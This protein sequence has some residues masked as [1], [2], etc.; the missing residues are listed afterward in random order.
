MYT[1]YSLG[2]TRQWSGICTQTTHSGSVEKAISLSLAVRFM[3]Q[4][5]IKGS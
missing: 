4:L 1:F 5:E 2:T 3:N